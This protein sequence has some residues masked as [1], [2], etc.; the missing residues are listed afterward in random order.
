MTY[1]K[2]ILTKINRTH[3]INLLINKKKGISLHRILIYLKNESL[4]RK[5]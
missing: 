5:P 3:I 1:K 2:E 4:H